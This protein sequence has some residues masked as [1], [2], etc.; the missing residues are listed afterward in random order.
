MKVY[1]VEFNKT[2]SGV[3]FDFKELPNA[4]DFIGMALESSTCDELKATITLADG[5]G[6][7]LDE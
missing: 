2:F 7:G 1:R 6:V 4:V 5:E 3:S